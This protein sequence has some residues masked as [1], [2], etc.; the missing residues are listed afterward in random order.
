MQPERVLITFP[1]QSMHNV[2]FRR[3]KMKLECSLQYRLKDNCQPL[4]AINL[5]HYINVMGEYEMFELHVL[6]S[7]E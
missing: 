1:L 3:Q 7:D 6:L 5:K 2:Y 4:C